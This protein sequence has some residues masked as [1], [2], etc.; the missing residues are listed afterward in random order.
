M[1]SYEDNLRKIEKLTAASGIDWLPPVFDKTDDVYQFSSR[2]LTLKNVPKLGDVSRK[3]RVRSG[4]HCGQ[5]LL[6]G[7]TLLPVRMMGKGIRMPS[8]VPLPCWGLV[9]F[10]G[11]V[12]LQ[13]CYACS[14]LK[15]RQGQP[16]KSPA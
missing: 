9:S 7:F 16:S 15:T 12:K 2:S 6:T 8:G 1:D 14:A 5:F 4:S 3:L 11:D 10:V 13:Q